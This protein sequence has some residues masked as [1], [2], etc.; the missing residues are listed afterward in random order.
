MRLSVFFLSALLFMATIGKST[1]AGEAEQFGGIGITIA[2]LYD[3]DTSTHLGELVVLAVPLESAA[4]K[5]GVKPGDVINA[6]DGQ[7]TK[8]SP[9]EDV[10]RKRLRG[11][12]GSE[13]RLSIR[14]EGRE[15]TLD[16][17]VIRQAIK[18]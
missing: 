10:V 3:Q 17:K 13:V 12:A 16:L 14:R 7:P 5:A 6:I 11:A 8:G 2:Q 4:A 1:G 18:G 9:F 15:S